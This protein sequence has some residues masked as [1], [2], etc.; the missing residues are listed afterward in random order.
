MTE[1]NAQEQTRMVKMKASD[2]PAHFNRRTSEYLKAAKQLQPGDAV[3]FAQIKPEAV[4]VIQRII[5]QA[6]YAR[7][8]SR[9][10]KTR[11]VLESD[12]LR[13]VYIYWPEE[14]DLHE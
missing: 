7:R 13:T 12:G 4:G 11:T 14:E 10:I 3:S 6:R 9:G 8:I 5:A 1:I 2:V